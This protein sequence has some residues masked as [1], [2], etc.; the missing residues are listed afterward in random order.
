MHESHYDRVVDGIAAA[1]DTVKLGDP[2]EAST[3][4]GALSTRAQF[5][6]TT[7]FI[8]RA[9]AAGVRMAGRRRA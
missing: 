5:D 2:T 9:R 7:G 8:E 6:K 1:F 3:E 4:M